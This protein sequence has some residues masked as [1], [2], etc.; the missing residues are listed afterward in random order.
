MLQ[1]KG[2]QERCLDDLEAY[3]RLVNQH[4]AQ[5]AFILQT[6]RTYLPVEQLPGLP[7]VCLRVP[8]GGG[9]TLMACHALG[10]ATRTYR[11]TDRALCLW[12]VPS[13]TIRDQTLKA[14]RD[15]QHPYRQAID[16]AFAG[17]VRVMDLTEALYI[18]RGILEGETLIIVSTLQALRVQ[19][20]EGRKIYEA[21]GVLKPIFD[22]LDAALRAK[23]ECYE[24]GEVT[25]S[26][27][28]VLK[29]WCPLV[30]M[31]EAHNARTE[32]SFDTLAR[33][34]PSCILEFTA[35]PETI[36][37]PEQK[38]FAS[39]VLCHVSAWELKSEEMIKLPIKLRTRADWKEVVAEAV[40]MQRA[41]EDA[42]RKEEQDTGQYL[43]PVVLL[44][45]Q[46]HSQE[47]QTLSVE[48]V[49][50]SLLDDFK[51]PEDQIA[52]ATGQTREIDDVDLFDRT[53]PFRFIITV[54]AL[55]EGWDCSFAYIL[56]SVA[57][58][59]ATRAVEQ[60]MGRVLRMPAAHR[61]NREELNCAYAFVASPRFAEAANALADA[62]VENGFE[63][64]EAKDLIVPP[65]ETSL[66]FISGPLFQSHSEHVSEP[67]DFSLMD[68]P[69]RTKVSFDQG[70]NTLS[71]AGKI[72]ESEMKV[73][74][75]CFANPQDRASVE[76]IYHRALGQ[77]GV[78]TAAAQTR[79]PFAVPLLGIR[80][81]GQLEPFDDSYF[82]EV[83]WRL[84]DCDSSLTEAEFPNAE[85]AGQEAVVDIGEAGR[86]EIR[87]VHELHEQLT[88][89]AS[90]RGWTVAALV[91]W[92]DRQIRH[93]DITQTQSSIFINQ[94]ITS[95]VESRHL[96]IEQ[97]ARRKF[98]LRD[99][100]ATKIQKH[101]Q[102]EASKGFSAL[103][104]G[105]GTSRL[106]VSPKLN[107]YFDENR[108][109][110]HENYRGAFQFKKHYF[111]QIGELKSEG[112][113]FECARFLDTH[114]SVW[115]WIRNI[116]RRPESSFWL[117]TS[118]D[119]FYPD[120]V[121]LLHDGR[122]LV[123]EYKG[124]DRWSDDD[125]KEKRALGELWAERSGGLCLFIM[126]KGLDWSPIE[127]LLQPSPRSGSR[128]F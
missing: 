113:E 29:L 119:K 73:I 13:N 15:R 99:A 62:L 52:V 71:I 11:Q 17:Q 81:D 105:E 24:N 48:V 32:L 1:L 65:V 107:F 125:S 22:G 27:A 2:Y 4:G 5:K 112:E 33:F 6:N 106:E 78:P 109:A 104:F 47:R 9:K 120:F 87:F 39:N 92:L 20:T 54:Q 66:P 55:K 41:L 7:Y 98:G 97:L 84:A 72:S 116:E 26:L 124:A 57:E 115:Y 30:I 101:R 96:T 75:G 23:L 89:L 42:A 74:Q 3:F 21:A 77:T 45:A 69:V 37:K 61:K 44:Q 102:S 31:D 94:A 38:R 53:C 67:P 43:R 28:N 114:R 68:E 40:Q 46:P 70:T 16:L 35:T 58:I 14:L 93:P 64:M 50:Q 82:K 10:I 51:I 85:A 127:V 36:H 122:I 56:C 63:K 76:Q 111:P 118:T 34:G 103:L 49:K 95:L 60:I 83:E 25:P 12:L 126:P 19:D 90:E 110:P 79:P 18:Q 117:Q 88:M 80:I 8:T 121:V 123:V 128:L 59:G 100:I 91:N 108:Y 86:V